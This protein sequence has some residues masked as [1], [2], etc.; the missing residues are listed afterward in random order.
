LDKLT[1]EVMAPLTNV[2][3]L[4]A[5]LTRNDISEMKQ[6]YSGQNVPAD[7]RTALDCVAIILQEKEDTDTIK[8]LINEGGFLNRFKNLDT[9]ATARK[10]HN[11]LKSKLSQNPNFKPSDMKGANLAAKLFCELSWHINHL[12]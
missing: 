11:S 12:P 5:S 8:K 1:S 7:L 4:I 6:L 10:V 9:L 3:E 2:L